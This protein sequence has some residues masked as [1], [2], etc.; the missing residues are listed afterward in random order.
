M[1]VSCSNDEGVF[2]K[3]V[4]DTGLFSISGINISVC[5]KNSGDIVIDEAV[6]A[7]HIAYG[8]ADESEGKDL[9]ISDKILVSAKAFNPIIQ[10]I[11]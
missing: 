3:A 10:K 1:L 8:V 4:Q 5:H 7:I 11:G 6:L 9:M 2:E